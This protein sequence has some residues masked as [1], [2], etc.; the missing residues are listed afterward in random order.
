MAS[1]HLTFLRHGATGPNLQGLRC[2]GDLDAPLTELGRLQATQAALR[3]LELRISVGVIVTSR[4]ARTRETAQIVS[5]ILHGV[6]IAIEP[7]FAERRLGAWNLRSV[8]ETED[9]LRQGVT[10]P[11]GE[12]NQK[13]VERIG[14]ALQAWLPRLPEQPLL[15]GSKGVA[16]V[17]R[18]LSGS[19]RPPRPLANGALAHF[20]LTAYALRCAAASPV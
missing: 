11:G 16:R 20:D 13:F 7:A 17:L 8:A 19:E 9:A 6:E 18:E 10:P 4:L 1:M 2:G 12:A 3:I 15:V 14:A 5:R